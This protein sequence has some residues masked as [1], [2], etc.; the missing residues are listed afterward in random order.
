MTETG[1]TR[2]QQREPQRERLVISVMGADRPGILSAITRVLADHQ[3][4]IVDIT[5]KIIEGLFLCLIVADCS[6]EDRTIVAVR[7]QVERTA[8]QLELKAIIQKERLFRFMHRV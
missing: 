4:N 7:Q 1:P 8:Q 3:V 6:A 5:Q 2:S